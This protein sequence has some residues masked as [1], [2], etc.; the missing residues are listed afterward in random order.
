MR[1]LVICIDGTGNSEEDA[2]EK[3]NDT[4]NVRRLYETIVD[5]EHQSP[6]YFPG[7]GN[8]KGIGGQLGKLFGSGADEV[9]THAHRT[10]NREFESDDQIYLFGFSRGATIARMLANS[11]NEKGIYPP[12]ADEK[13]LASLGKKEAEVQF[14]GVWDTV[15]AFGVPFERIGGLFKNWTVA[16]NVR[17][18]YHLVSIDE[19]RGPFEPELMNNE[20][21]RIEEVWFPGVH[22]DV[23]GGYDDRELAEIPL[24]FMIRAASDH[25]LRF[26]Q[27]KVA[28]IAQNEGD[29]GKIHYHKTKIPLTDREIYCKSNDKK[30]PDLKPKIHRAAVVRMERIQMYEPTPLRD[31]HANYEI[32]D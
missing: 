5:D 30:N 6:F 9:M 12:D 26:D 22:S 7:V 1:N 10:L 27:E 3:D 19:N 11:I 15:A 20:P 8:E 17:K 21:G 4:T 2:V 24:R 25:G 31:L 28:D 14:L 13:E 29:L 32:V 23:G 18:A 16:T